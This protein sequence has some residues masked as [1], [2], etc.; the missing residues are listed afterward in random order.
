MDRKWILVVVAVGCAVLDNKDPKPTKARRTSTSERR[1]R[2]EERRREMAR[3]DELPS[4]TFRIP[5]V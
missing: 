1:E 2:L 4:I 5:R 3:A